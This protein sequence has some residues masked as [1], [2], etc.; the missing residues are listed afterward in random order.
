MKHLSTI[1]VILAFS[2][3]V[4][5]QQAKRRGGRPHGPPPEAIEACSNANANDSCSFEGRRGEAL[6]GTCA[7]SPQGLACRPEGKPPRHGNDQQDDR[8][9]SSSSF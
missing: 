9:D 3:F 4:N 2:Q 8:G 5:A 1:L 6:S 7:D